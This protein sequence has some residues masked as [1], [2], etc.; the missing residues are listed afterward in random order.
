MTSRRGPT[1]RSLLRYVAF[2]AAGAAVAVCGGQ[3]CT[4]TEKPKPYGVEAQSYLP[5]RRRQ[6][7]AIAPAVNLSGERADPILQSDLVYGQLQQV[8]GLTVIPVNRV[9]EVYQALRIVRVQSE[10][11]AAL[12]CDLLGCD[13]LVIPTITAYDPYDPP[14]LGASLQLFLKPVDYKRP[15][16]VDPRELA[17]Q[18]TPMDVRQALPPDATFVQAVGIYDAAN[19]SVRDALFRY[20]SGRNDPVGPYGA[21]EYLVSMDRY[22]GFVYYVLIEEL[23]ASPRLRQIG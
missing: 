9:F 19:G 12:V 11:Q 6:V 13:G 5:A 18:A 21:R 10:K 8:K 3:G 23:I 16:L 15:A 1:R 17:R 2:S 22:C 14:K 4:K 7:W 20:A